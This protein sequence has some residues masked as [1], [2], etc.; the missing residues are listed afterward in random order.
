[1]VLGCGAIGSDTVE[2]LIKYSDADVVVADKNIQKVENLIKKLNTD[3]IDSETID[4]NN[5]NELVDIIKKVNPDVVAST[6]GPFYLTAEKIYN[7]CIEAKINC[8]DICDDPPGTLKALSLHEECQK[9]NMTI[10]TGAGDSP[11]LPNILA[12]YGADKMDDVQ[13]INIYWI[14]P[15]AFAGPAQF[16]HG[17]NMYEHSHQFIEG[18]LIEYQGKVTTE[19]L[20]PFN[21]YEVYY[22]DHP[23]P[24]TIPRFIEGVKNVINAGA[25]YPKPPVPLPDL[26]K[27]SALIK[28]PIDLN[29]MEIP[30]DKY[31]VTLLKSLI[32][33]SLGKWEEEGIP[34]ELGATRI[35]IIGK[36]D[37]FP[38]K[39]VFSGIGRG[40]T[41]TSRCLATIAK[42]VAKNQ[43]DLK[44]AFAPEGCIDP[45]L[46]IK[47]FSGD[48]LQLKLIPETSN[49]SLIK[50][51]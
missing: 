8:V 17:L 15:W 11:G 36:K 49:I 24:Y 33:A 51:E 42:M 45:E 1:M 50:V 28:D 35:E 44:G 39:Y 10:I 18:E 25:V 30:A 37:G 16:Y 27:I 34:F 48:K 7:A 2:Q 19:F 20:P 3:K 40:S 32:D 26:S 41:G 12:R 13:D 46:F 23:E 22:C 21:Q 38:K 14:S 6:I 47:E 9:A 4:I 43:V 5:Q 31:I 29:G